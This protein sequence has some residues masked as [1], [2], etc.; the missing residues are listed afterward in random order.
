MNDLTR[1][2]RAATRIGPAR[3]RVGYRAAD[4]KPRKFFTMENPE[5]WHVRRM[6]DGVGYI[7]TISTTAMEDGKR[8]TVHEIHVIDDS[9]DPVVIVDHTNYYEEWIDAERTTLAEYLNKLDK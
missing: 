8:V 1:E 5:G 6:G 3:V 7:F 2:Q 9:T 4:G